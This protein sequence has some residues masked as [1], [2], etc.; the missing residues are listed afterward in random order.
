LIQAVLI[1]VSDRSDGT[2][3]FSKMQVTEIVRVQ[4][5]DGSMNTQG[6]SGSLQEDCLWEKWNWRA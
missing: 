2:K 6:P 1:R 4:L 5:G 3:G